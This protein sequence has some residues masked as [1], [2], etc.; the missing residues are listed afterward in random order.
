MLPRPTHGM[1]SPVIATGLRAGDEIELTVE[2]SGGAPAPT[3][4]PH[5]L[6]PV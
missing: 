4:S 3:T 6:K 2:P 5:H 1:T